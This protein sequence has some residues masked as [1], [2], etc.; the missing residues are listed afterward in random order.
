MSYT[1]IC[2]ELI[3]STRYSVNW[4]DFELAYVTGVNRVLAEPVRQKLCKPKSVKRTL[5]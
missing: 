5:P 4:F 3:S 1:K 2:F